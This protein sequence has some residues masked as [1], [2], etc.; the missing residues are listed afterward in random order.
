MFRKIGVTTRHVYVVRVSVFTKFVSEYLVA[1]DVAASAI[2]FHCE[3]KSFCLERAYI[4]QGR[5]ATFT[6]YFL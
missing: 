5:G 2:E 6:S 1:K 3:S 4:A